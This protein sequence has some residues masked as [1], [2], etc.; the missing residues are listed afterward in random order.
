MAIPLHSDTVWEA[1]ELY[2]IKLKIY[3]NGRIELYR[4]SSEIM[5][6]REGKTSPYD[7]RF[8]SKRREKG[9]GTHSSNNLYRSFSRLMDLSLANSD[10]FKTFITLTFKN[11]VKDLTYANK[12]FNNWVS[13]VRKVCPD[14]EY[15]GTPEFQKR[16]AVHYHL[17]TNQDINS[18]MFKGQE[19][20]KNMYDV[21]Y[22]PHGFT[23]VFDYS[24]TD[25]NFSIALYMAKYFFKDIDSRLFGRRKILASKGLKEPTVIKIDSREID[26]LDKYLERYE[27]IKEKR[28]I[29]RNDYS[30]RETLIQSLKLKNE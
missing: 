24:T 20:K 29:A 2:D 26:K 8:V 13:N 17:T 11:N 4:Y 21:I 15:L 5:A 12:K 7:N 19:G 14:F 28:I 27:V 16:G 3:G 6:L 9:T 18:K 30:P 22:W 25:E 1:Y 10:I 23:S